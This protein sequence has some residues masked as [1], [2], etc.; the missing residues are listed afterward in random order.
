MNLR[1][2]RH[3]P[4]TAVLLEFRLQSH[5]SSFLLKVQTW[6]LNQFRIYLS[7]LAYIT[8][9]DDSIYS[10]DRIVDDLRSYITCFCIS[11]YL[12]FG[13]F[14][15]YPSL[16]LLDKLSKLLLN[17]YLSLR[18]DWEHRFLRKFPHVERFLSI[19]S[20]HPSVSGEYE[21]CEGI[22]YDMRRK[23]RK[24]EVNNEADNTALTGALTGALT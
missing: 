14:I 10:M 8:W 3:W 22:R 12:P 9:P 21:Y 7:I 6:A 2:S 23:A 1:R 24:Q 19:T 5:L 17:R 13:G 20:S 4:R 18:P 16:T 11:K 15:K